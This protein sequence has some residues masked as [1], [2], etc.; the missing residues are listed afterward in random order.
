MIADIELAMKAGDGFYRRRQ[1][2]A[3]LKAFKRARAS[4]YRILHPEFDIP[5]YLG[6]KDIPLP[7]VRSC[8]E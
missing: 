2:D 6:S 5:S 4:I 3:A 1:Y 7:D 8:Y